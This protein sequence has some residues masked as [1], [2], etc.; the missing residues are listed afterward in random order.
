MREQNEPATASGETKGEAADRLFRMGYNCCQS[1]ACAFAPEMGLPTETV[2]RLACGFGGG[3][4]RLRETCG[5]V[6]GMVLVAG[7]LRGYSDP[8]AVDEKTESYALI[9]TLAAK[10]RAANGSL[11]CRELLGLDAVQTPDTPPQAEARTAEY[12]EKRPCPELCR[13]AA[14]IL[15]DTLFDTSI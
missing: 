10:F 12:Y 13:M 8:G 5:A 15:A 2:A 11:I 7:M 9:Q 6:S 4:G 3:I 14:Q 1:V